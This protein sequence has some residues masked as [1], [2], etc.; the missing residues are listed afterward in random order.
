MTTYEPAYQMPAAVTHSPQQRPREFSHLSVRPLSGALGA[1][2]TGVELAT[3][4]ESGF[5]E[6]NHAL[7]DHQ[8]LTFP[9]Q[10]LSMTAQASFASRFGRLM[11][12]SFVKAVPGH[13]FITEIR[14]E[15]TDRFNF[16]GVWHT[17]SMNF[18]RPPKITMLRCVETPVIGGDTSFASLYLAWDSLSAGL[19]KLLRN[20]RVVA[21]TSLSYGTS[22]EIGTDEFKQQISTPTQMEPGE[23]DEEFD[24]PVA[25]THPETGRLALYLSR[26]YSAR[27]SNMTRE[28]SLPLMRYLWEHA[29]QPSFTCRVSWKPGTLTM[30]D[31]RCCMH[32][33]HNDY[34][35]QV[36]LMRRTIVE[37]ERPY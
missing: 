13:P 22:T 20:R 18:E 31:N 21:A 8:V 25:R 16:G 36:R 4:S 5:D 33:A 10:D 34:P 3:L 24:H 35:G 7:A 27:F 1:E 29:I 14:S 2:I 32:Y 26:D 9:D 6:V 12:Y 19:R 23:E 30:W 37:G 15:P 17:D 11:N 28:E